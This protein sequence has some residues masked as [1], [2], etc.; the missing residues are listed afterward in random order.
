MRMPLSHQAAELLGHRA[1]VIITA[2]VD[3][4]ALLIGQ[5]IPMGLPEVLDRPIPRH[6]TQRGRR[7]G[8][9][10][11]MGLA[12]R[13]TAGE[14]RQVAVAGSLQGR[15]HPLSRLTA[16]VIQPLDGRDDRRR[17]LL[18][19][20]SKPTY[21]HQSARD[22]Q[23]RS[24]AVHA[25]PQEVLRGD[26]PTVSGAHAVTAEGLLQLGQSQ[27]EPT[28]PPLQGMLGALAPVGRPLATEVLAGER[29]DEGVALARM[30]RLRPG[31]Q[32]TGLL[33]VGAGQRRAWATRASL[34]GHHDGS[35]SPLP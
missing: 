18:T 23:A 34:T 21:G 14:P 6:G 10:A 19:P 7:W 13:L 24:L 4:V 27:A 32:T 28:R 1:L 12:P 2:R 35:V 17:P 25:L 9:T 16:H 22:L 33:V 26:A 8:W 30:E 15:P 20:W 5:M 31:V 29:A 11:V 3:D